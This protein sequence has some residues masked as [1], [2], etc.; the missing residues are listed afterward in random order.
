MYL[1]LV[2]RAHETIGPLTSTNR[3]GT[4][5]ANSDC[6]GRI[7]DP[8]DL[9]ACVHATRLIEMKGLK[10]AVVR[11][12]LSNIQLSRTWQSDT[13]S[14]NN[15]NNNNNNSSHGGG[16]ASGNTS[17]GSTKYR[18]PA[19]PVKDHSTRGFF[20]SSSSSSSQNTQ[21]PVPPPTSTPAANTN[22][23]NNQHLGK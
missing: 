22:I 11:Y 21:S 12:P 9:S 5:T 20:S 8:T 17:S 15:S 2:P 4:A 19:P 6:D 7:S 10:K 16:N 18:A 3:L 13:H 23:S 1:L 14:R